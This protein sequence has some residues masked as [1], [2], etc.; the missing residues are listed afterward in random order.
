MQPVMTT[1][2]LANCSRRKNRQRITPNTVKGAAPEQRAEHLQPRG[3]ATALIEILAGQQRR[4]EDHHQRSQCEITGK[5]FER[6]QIPQREGIAQPVG[7]A[8]GSAK[9]TGVQSLEEADPRL[10]VMR[11]HGRNAA[12]ERLG[13]HGAILVDKRE[14]VRSHAGRRKPSSALTT[15]FTR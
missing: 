13:V 14:G 10:P 9:Q 15:L 11:E 8:P 4:A 5:R 2:D 7:D 3:K 6:M 1:T 12:L